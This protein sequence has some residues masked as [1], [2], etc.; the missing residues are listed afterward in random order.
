MADPLPVALQL[1]SVRDVLAS[2]FE[3]TLEKVAEM[4][5]A[6]VEFCNLYGHKPQDVAALLDR[7][8]LGR[9]GYHWGFKADDPLGRVP[10]MIEVCGA[11]ELRWV[12]APSLPKECRGSA[13]AYEKGAKALSRIGAALAEAGIRY[14][15]HNHAAEFEPLDG[16]RRGMDIL[17]EKTDPKVVDLQFD[18]YWV[19][20]GGEDPAAY[21]RKYADR[22]QLVHIK[23]GKLKPT[24]EHTVVGDGD[25]DLGAVVEASR[26]AGA[27]WLIV[28][29]E[30]A[31]P[32]AGSLGDAAKSLSF[33][34]GAGYV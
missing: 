3:G 22:V 20:V 12:T 4:G 34:R 19:A 28:E 17:I 23:D 16:G 24:V 8:R 1:Y 26:A 5:Y 13:A 30:T 31:N 33:L 21:I 11:L 6:G 14:G 25:V 15:Y 27:H 32:E 9:A 18:V 7:L 10:E 2:D 29:V